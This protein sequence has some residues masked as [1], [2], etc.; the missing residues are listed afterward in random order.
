MFDIGLG[1]NYPEVYPSALKLHFRNHLRKLCQSVH[2]AD[3]LVL[4]LTGPAMSDGSM[5]LWDVDGNGQV[6]QTA[7]EKFFFNSSNIITISQRI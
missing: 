1:E 4:Y 3:S 2:C 7:H 5:L 6:S